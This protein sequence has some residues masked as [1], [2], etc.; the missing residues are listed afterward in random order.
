M[1]I[2]VESTVS[3]ILVTIEN[4]SCGPFILQRAYYS[5]NRKWLT[6]T[7]NGFADFTDPEETAIPLPVNV[8]DIVDSFDLTDG[9]YEYRYYP[10]SI[11]EPIYS[12]YVFSKYVKFGKPDKIGYSFN[13]YHAPE[14][15][16]GTVVTPDD[17]RF[18]YLWGTDFKATNGEFFSDEQI[19]WFIDA[20]T[21]EVERRLN[22]NIVKKHIFLRLVQTEKLKVLIM[23]K[24]KHCMIF[25]IV[26]C[27]DME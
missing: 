23:M 1:A 6:Y 15:K 25:L 13:N 11:E 22:I 8:G 2:S 27:K 24:K 18:T 12:D 26:K 21:R 9:L 17:C 16:W 10:S 19:Q 14:G 20:A 3:K 7:E 4:D 5:S